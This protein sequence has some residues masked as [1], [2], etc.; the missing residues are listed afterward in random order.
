MRTRRML[1]ALG[2]MVLVA[3]AMVMLP[4]LSAS[5]GSAV[6][7]EARSA[8]TCVV[9]APG[10]VR[11]WGNNQ[12]GYLGDGTTT[13]RDIPTSVVGLDSGVVDVAVG[14]EHACAL[15]DEGIV[16]CWGRN[17]YGEVGDGTTR[18][19]LTPVRVVGLPR[20]VQD[21]S[22]GFGFTCA[23]TAFQTVKCWG[24]NDAG[25]LGTDA[26]LASRS[27]VLVEGV[28]ST[29]IELASGTFHG[30]AVLDTGDLEC[31]G[32]NKEGQLGTGD[33]VNRFE[34]TKVALDNPVSVVAGGVWHTCAISDG[35]P[36]CWGANSN[37]QLGDGTTDQ[38]LSP[39]PVTGGL[40]GV[41][42]IATGQGH[43]CAVD[44]A[45]AAWCWGFDY[46]G[47]LGSGKYES[48]QPNPVPVYSLG[49]GV[50]DIAVGD[51]HSCAVKVS[52]FTA[53]WGS[54]SWSAL[55]TGG[56]SW[57]RP[58]PANVW[59][60]TGSTSEVLQPDALVSTFSGPFIGRDLYNTTAKSQTFQ[61]KLA[62]GENVEY[63]A[64]FV[65]DSSVT[66]TIFLTPWRSGGSMKYRWRIFLGDTDITHSYPYA[67]HGVV[68]VPGE[69]LT[70]RMR[71]YKRLSAPDFHRASIWFEATSAND[72][73]A[74]DVVRVRVS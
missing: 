5:A 25:Q 20:G 53:C 45:G 35:L 18:M 70:I 38:R 2:S 24:R 56:M 17:T 39:V 27:P 64:R 11:C 54:S 47:V 4:A 34:A 43:T 66:D 46:S 74:Q 59:G 32:G 28:T 26:V 31:W 63:F 9:T 14:D 62:P 50:A 19:R 8:H 49:E 61:T 12:F 72:S 42:D 71:I 30:C 48:I 13:T 60:L 15:T 37:G 69:T 73:Q 23:I 10:G 58:V 29:P 65:N 44:G 33:T 7:I 57:T 67:D 41:T 1:A 40:S 36:W 55:G 52:G 3:S 22:A 68:L 51:G 21:I 16:K 6:V